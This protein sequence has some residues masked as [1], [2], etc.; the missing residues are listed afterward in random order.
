[1]ALKRAQR[2]KEE[3]ERKNNQIKAAAMKKNE[4]LPPPRRGPVA[5]SQMPSSIHGAQPNGGQA[6]AIVVNRRQQSK[7]S[8]SDALGFDSKSNYSAMGVNK[9]PSTRNKPLPMD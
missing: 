6:N 3:E 9:V 8:A 5:G 1:M 7:Q 2:E 4:V